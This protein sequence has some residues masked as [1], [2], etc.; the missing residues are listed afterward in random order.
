MNARLRYQ[1][2]SPIW[3]WHSRY[4]VC[5]EKPNPWRHGGRRGKKRPFVTVHA[6]PRSVFA[7]RA[8]RKNGW[9]SSRPPRSWLRAWLCFCEIGLQS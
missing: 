6:V 9:R 8:L 7:Y 5:R 3:A 1:I 2:M 4:Q